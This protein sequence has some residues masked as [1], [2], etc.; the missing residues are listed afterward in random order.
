MHLLEEGSKEP[1]TLS[2]HIL[3]SYCHHIANGMDCFSSKKFVQ[4]CGF[5]ETM[6]LCDGEL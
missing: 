1:H 5:Y 6:E 3:L 2:D 4:E